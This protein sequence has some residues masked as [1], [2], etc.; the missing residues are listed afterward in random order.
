M[1]I[2]MEWLDIHG[3]TSE[4]LGRRKYKLL[5]VTLTCLLLISAY[6]SF[7]MRALVTA[8]NSVYDP[9]TFQATDLNAGQA[10]KLRGQPLFALSVLNGKTA[11]EPVQLSGLETR[12]ES[13]QKARHCLAQAM[14]FEARS[15]P[16]EGWQAVGDVV[17]NRVRDKRYP[18]TVCKVVFQGEF[19]RHRCQFSF[20]CDG[21][22]DRA[23][24]R[25]FWDAAYDLAG[26]LLVK[27]SNSEIA[28]L[29]THYHADYVEPRWSSY[30]EPITKIGR[31]IFYVE[32][33]QGRKPAPLSR[34]QK[35][36]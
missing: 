33:P 20:A 17:I 12:T 9:Q 23:Y 31:H 7:N 21:R 22:S 5:S 24:N 34:P 3:L 1:R 13:F 27:G 30:M 18:D 2:L 29:A 25:K 11:L 8:L 35:D 28:G 32:D 26:E 6:T 16:L 10:E 36:L 4:F 15:E 14:Y 19:R